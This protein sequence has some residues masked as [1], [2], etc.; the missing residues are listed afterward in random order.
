MKEPFITAILLFLPIIVSSMY[1]LIKKRYGLHTSRTVICFLLT[2]SSIVLVYSFVAVLSS[3]N[4]NEISNI[5]PSN[6][7]FVSAI[8]IFIGGLIDIFIKQKHSVAISFVMV[9]LPAY[10]LII[11]TWKIITL[12]LE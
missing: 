7:V 5:G 6:F 11:M 10:S 9:F 8:I 2:I 12:L 4:H 3:V 1:Y